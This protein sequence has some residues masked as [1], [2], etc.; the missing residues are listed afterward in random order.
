MAGRKFRNRKRS[1]H[2]IRIGFPLS[3]A[4]SHYYFLYTESGSNTFFPTVFQLPGTSPSC[5]R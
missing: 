2:P 3:F 4:A 5:S 1:L